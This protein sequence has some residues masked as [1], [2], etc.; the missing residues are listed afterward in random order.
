MTVVIIINRIMMGDTYIFRCAGPDDG[1]VIEGMEA[2]PTEPGIVSIENIEYAD[3]FMIA[4]LKGIKPGQTQVEF[5]MRLNDDESTGVISTF[6]VH[7]TGFITEGSFIG[8]TNH[9]YI[10]GIEFVIF[11]LVLLIHRIWLCVKIA[12]ENMYSY[13]LV[14]HMGVALFM[15]ALTVLFI[16]I[17][18]R[19][20]MAYYKLYVMTNALALVCTLFSW[21]AF[22]IIFILSVFMVVSN[23]TLMKKE[24]K[25]ITNSLG[26]ALGLFLCFA[27]FGWLLVGK[28]IN[29]I[30]FPNRIFEYY[31][32]NCM[33]TFIY[34]VLIYLECLMATTLFCT[35]KAQRH[36]PKPDMD[37]IIILGCAINKD[38]TPTPLLKG[39]A[40]RALW[41]AKWQKEKSGKDI[42]FVPSGGQGSDEV[43]SEAESIKNYLIEQ[44]VDEEHILLENKSTN[45]FENMSFSK[46]L[47]EEQDPDAKVAFSTTGY[48]VFRSGNIARRVGLH[49]YGV[50]SKTKWYFYVNA[51]IR[52]FVAN[53]SAEKKRHITN[54]VIL[55]LYSLAVTFLTY[56]SA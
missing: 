20:G 28:L 31:A 49:A 51:L 41:F 56:I 46:K 48:H 21:A 30:T 19:Q 9:F 53:L 2:L 22:P 26:I 6:Y 16:L 27:T 23:I 42:I 39:R 13:A 5:G 11:L 3:G 36:V 15:A 50:G 43:I 12:K 55:F 44:G 47:I 8:T 10:I 33:T 1:K 38:G 24:G 45:T 18:I 7:R 32:E 17:S 29:L 14:G 25:R 52:E 54:V 35:V 34:S 4:T 40:D 37:Y